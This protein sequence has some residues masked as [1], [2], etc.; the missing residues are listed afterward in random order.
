MCDEQIKNVKFKLLGGQFANEP[1][2]HGGGQIIP[3]SRRATYSSFLLA[4]PRIMEPILLA[5]ILCP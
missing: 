5:E 4:N 2:Y 1:I 3:T